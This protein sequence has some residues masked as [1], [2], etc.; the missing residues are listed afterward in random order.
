VIEARQF[1]TSA[2]QTITHVTEIEDF[3]EDQIGN[4]CQTNGGIYSKYEKITST[5]C[6]CQV[7]QSTE[8]NSKIVGIIVSEDKFASHGDALVKVC[9]GTYSLG[10]LLV[11]EGDF[12]RVATQEE[13]MEIAINAIPR[14]KITSLTTG[15]E[16][17]VACFIS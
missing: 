9:S 15:I 3:S 5:D 17:M 16:G 8:L 2:S 12:A 10:D 13:K 6:I 14:V 11:P 7:I 1:I 4:F